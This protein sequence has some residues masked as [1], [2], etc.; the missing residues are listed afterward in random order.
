MGNFKS[1]FFMLVHYKCE[2]K[3]VRLN[4]YFDEQLLCI[5][6]VCVF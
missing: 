1:A 6:W 3:I 4:V 2:T 5:M